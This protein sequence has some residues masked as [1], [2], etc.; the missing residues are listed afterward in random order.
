MNRT[1]YLETRAGQV[2]ERVKRFLNVIYFSIDLEPKSKN[3]ISTSE[4]R[5]FREELNNYLKKCKRR[6]FRGDIILEIDFSTTQD[7]PPA[8]QTLVK[9]YLDLMHKPLPTIDGYKEILFK[10]DSQI[11]TL[12][13]NYHLNTSGRNKPEISLRAYRHNYFIQ[14]VELADRII[15]GRFNNASNYAHKYQNIEIEEN[16]ESINDIYYKLEKLETNKNWHIKHLGKSDFLIYK[17]LLIRQIQELYLQKNN[18][19]I[20]DLISLYRASFDYT[21]KYQFDKNFQHLFELSKNLISMSTNLIELGGA[22]AYKGD[23]KKF[24]S[25]LKNKLNAF[26]AKYKILFPLLQPISVTIFYTSP[27]INVLDLD[28]LARYIIPLLLKLF[29]PP[30]N[31]LITNDSKYLNVAR[32]RELVY[33]QRFP[34]NGIANYQLIHQPRVDDTPDEGL[35]NFYI[36][37][38]I[39]W[40]N[41]IWR[42]IDNFIEKWED[43]ND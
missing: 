20:N 18:I 10:N 9:N 25:N 24:K 7:N 13:A 36:T 43:D 40:K 8:I 38:G 26:K 35:I 3:A 32:K 29:N 17:Q 16:L 39:F 30:S 34:I 23:T 42:T 41:N 1:E 31:R 28:N 4:K 15:I 27:K 5:R 14:D 37:E 6:A 19:S 33:C 22:P 12:I 11:K 2:N 21:K